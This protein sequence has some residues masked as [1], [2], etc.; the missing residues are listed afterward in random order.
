MDW[1]MEIDA[2]PPRLRSP[3]VAYRG[4]R[5]RLRPLWAWSRRPLRRLEPARED[6]RADGP[7]LVHL[8]RKVEGTR[9]LREFAQALRAHPPGVEHELVLA[10]KGFSAPEDARD[11][12]RAVEDLR[13]RVLFFP[14]RRFD[15]GVY[16]AAAARLRRD[17]YCF[18]NSNG[19]PLV[20]GWLAKLDAALGG[21]G[22]GQVGVTG[23]WASQH[24]WLTY[25]MGLP[26]AYRNLMPP[27]SLAR[28]LLLEVELDR[29]GKARRSL[30]E[31]AR[32][33]L[34]TLVRVPEELLGFAP[35]PTP[36]LRPNTFMI[37]HAALS[38]LRLFVV[39]SKMDTLA[40]E[41]GRE[42]ITS[43][44]RRLGLTSLV[45]DRDGAVYGP[46]RWDRSRTLWQGRQEGLLVADNQTRY[47]A[48]GDD[49]R[50][51][52]LST[53]AWGPAAD[54]RPRLSQP[55]AR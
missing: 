8:V 52:I 45:V 36:H 51:E 20:D 22:V 53:L 44:L 30:S 32:A 41:S 12:L 40:L 27:A 29:Y 18:V 24:S 35:F 10:M 34:R 39:V 43:Q 50:R 23:S 47:Y 25:S 3:C 16:F 17:R 5:T 9:P 42:S 48:E 26:S 7:C 13:P 37:S 14:D 2:S 19:R 31:A 11:H 15:L 21:V 28:R 55:R 33:R 46:E 4:S 49:A 54:P 38:E 1:K 6:S